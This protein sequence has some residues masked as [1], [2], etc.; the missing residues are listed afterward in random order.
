[1]IKRQVFDKM[2]KAYPN[3]VI[4][5]DQVINGKNERLP[6]MYNFFDTMFIPEKG[7][8]LGEDFAF[9]KRWKDIG[10][11]CYAWIMDHITHVGEHQY[12]GRFGDEL[13]KLD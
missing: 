8:Y 6:N 10:G 5:Q 7:H 2:I 9:C 1:M 3:S 12:K 4:N 13:I 11:K